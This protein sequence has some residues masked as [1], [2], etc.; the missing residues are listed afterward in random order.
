M[1]QS[2]R[3]AIV[4]LFSDATAAK[5]E[6]DQAVADLERVRRRLQNVLDEVPLDPDDA[7][8]INR[9][10][11]QNEFEQARREFRDRYEE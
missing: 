10:I 8:V 11:R 9:H 2:H 3:D 7:E 5:H 4:D 6:F 1:V